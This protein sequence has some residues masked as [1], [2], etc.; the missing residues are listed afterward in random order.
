MGSIPALDSYT[1][2]SIVNTL[3]AYYS[4]TGNNERLA[5]QL[6]ERVPSDLDQIVDKKKRESMP[7]C[8]FAALFKRKTKI[9]FSKEPSDY[10]RVVVV[11]PF[12]VGSLPPATRTYLEENGPRL[13]QFAILSVCGTGEDN[14]KA[15]PDVEAT[16]GKPVFASL[17]VKVEELQNDSTQQK[18]EE[19]IKEIQS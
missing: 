4:R 12:W 19:F 9:E 10:D 5:K 15:I 2:G 14:T 1:R 13:K 7:G 18:I 6:H 11:T 8:A 16:A 17:L 3:I